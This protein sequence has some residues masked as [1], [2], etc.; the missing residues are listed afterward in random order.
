MATV[1]LSQP[2]I[3]AVGYGSVAGSVSVTGGS[4]GAPSGTTYT[5]KVCTNAAMTTGCINPVDTT[6]VPGTDLTGIPYGR[7]R[8]RDLLRHAHR[9][10][11]NGLPRLLNAFTSMSHADTSKVGVPG[12]PTGANGLTTGSLTVTFG[13]PTGVAPASYSVEACTGPQWLGH[14]HHPKRNRLGRSSSRVS[15]RARG[16]TC[17]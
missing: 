6:Y 3:G 14:L 16:T 1:Q 13:A 10:Q 11:F 8:R 2:V 9:E 7:R 12:T 17:R 4:S 5:A 15:S